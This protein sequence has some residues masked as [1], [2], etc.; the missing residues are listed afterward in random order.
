MSAQTMYEAFAPA[1]ARYRQQV[2][3]QTWGHLA[4]RRNKKY[5]GHVVFALGCYDGGEH[6]PTPLTSDFK[7]LSDSPWFYDALISFLESLGGEGGAVY[8][9]DG[10]FRNYEF[11]GSTRRLAL[12]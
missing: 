7:D 4:P 9:F 8:R 2:A 6:N 12:I 10:Y 1:E 3:Q 11:V 5:R